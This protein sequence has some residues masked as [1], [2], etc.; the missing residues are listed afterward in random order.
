MDL[1]IIVLLSVA[2][3][4]ANFFS[5]ITGG[6]GLILTPLLITFGIPPVQAIAATKFSYLGTSVTGTI[7]FHREKRIDYKIALPLAVFGI[8]GA[9]IGATLV[10]S[11][12]PHLLKIFIGLMMLGILA[13]VFIKKDLGESEHPV[14]ITHGRLII[15]GFLTLIAVALGTMAGGG[16]VVLISYILVILFGASFLHS[17]GTQKIINDVAFLII[18]AIFIISG[19]VNY[20]IAIPM[21]IAASLGGWF[22]AQYGISKGVHWVKHA[23]TVAVILMSINIFLSL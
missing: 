3:F 17:A 19:S 5:V 4:G 23:F 20:A 9:L 18:A 8:A 15:G 10:L 11:A 13:L 14:K 7:K 1:A 2:A 16:L 12:E 6:A 21:L 22:G